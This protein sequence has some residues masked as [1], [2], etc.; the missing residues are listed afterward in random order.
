MRTLKGILWLVALGFLLLFTLSC[1][2]VARGNM[3][4]RGIDGP[5]PAQVATPT[6]TKAPTP[7]ITPTPPRPTPTIIR[8]PGPGSYPEPRP[9]YPPGMDL[10]VPPPPPP[11]PRHTFPPPTS[12]EEALAQVEEARKE[13]GLKPGVL[14]KTEG[15]STAGGKIVIGKT[16][17]K[18]PDDAYI[19]GRVSA[20]CGG[21]PCPK[22]PVY[23]IMRGKSRVV[24]SGKDG[25]VSEE[26]I[27]PG[28]SGAFDFLKDHLQKK[29]ANR[30]PLPVPQVAAPAATGP[31]TKGGNIQIAGR[32][33][34][35]PDD[36]YVDAFIGSY[37]CF[38]DSCPKP[39]V[40]R[41][42][43]GNSW[44]EF[45]AV[46]GEIVEKRVGEGDKSTVFN[47]LKSLLN[48]QSRRI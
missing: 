34:K 2:P 25:E 5:A 20:T 8:T 29:A 43:V 48:L 26:L 31:A 38:Y 47:H 27:A 36:T 21:G 30:A 15:P 22:S 4:V 45:S 13:L 35:L 7:T 16:I 37:Y 41:V 12:Y 14:E 19:D 28:E 24:F 6:P 32:T 11:P 18:L 9:T 10:S 23:G 39:P 42:K 3:P 33:F 40:Y 44:I 46:D 1:H 17:I